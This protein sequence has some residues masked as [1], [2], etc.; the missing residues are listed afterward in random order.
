MLRVHFGYEFGCVRLEYEAVSARVV[1]TIATAVRPE[2]W[3]YSNART[4]EPLDWK[5]PFGDSGVG[6]G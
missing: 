4:G 3:T 1:H 5:D 2:E 6:S